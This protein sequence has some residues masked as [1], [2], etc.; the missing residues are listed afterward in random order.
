MAAMIWFNIGFWPRV[1]TQG[2]DP[3]PRVLTHVQQVLGSEIHCRWINNSLVPQHC[4]SWQP[5]SERYW[6]PIP[7]RQCHQNLTLFPPTAVCCNVLPCVAVSCSVSDIGIQPQAGNVI[8]I[9]QL[10]FYIGP[11]THTHVQ[12][13]TRMN[14]GG[15]QHVFKSEYV[16][17]D[18]YISVCVYQCIYMC[19]YIY[20]CI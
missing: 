7:V 1:L 4:A 19:T 15:K 13:H 20:I 6:D 17:I 2:S 10:L 18:V 12:T 9:S 8:K 16:Y 3:C 5:W 11:H 14:V